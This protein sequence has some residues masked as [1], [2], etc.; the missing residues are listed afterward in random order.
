MSLESL[1]A[2]LEKDVERRKRG[3]FLGIGKVAET[4]ESLELV[5]YPY[6]EAEIDF[7]VAQRE[8]VGLLKKR[9]IY[10]V[11]KTTASVDASTGVLVQTSDVGIS[12]TYSY[13]PN[14]TKDEIAIL[15]VVRSDRFDISSVLALGFSEGKARRVITS[16][17]GKGVLERLSGRPVEYKS[18]REFPSDP[19][20]LTSMT[21][22]FELQ[23]RQ[24]SIR[25]Y[26]GPVKEPNS[27]IVALESYWN[28]ATVAG[29]SLLLLPVLS[30]GLQETRRH[31]EK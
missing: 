24:P 18:L 4:L 14:L 30:G 17:C 7:Q 1:K 9:Q 3:G 12:Y 10:E 19:R 22:A 16:L 11:A 31:C 23:E 28:G 29:L 26:H 15:R 20:S 27:I 8:R 6:Y 21:K 2:G 13:L 5:Y 25:M